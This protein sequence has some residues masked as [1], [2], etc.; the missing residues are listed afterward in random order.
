MK[1]KYKI[2][3]GVFVI[4]I[5]AS[6]I[7]YV[8]NLM[9][10]KNEQENFTLFDEEDDTHET[11]EKYDNKTTKEEKTPIKQETK[12]TYDTRILILK[13]I[14]KIKDINKDIK[15]KLVDI[16]FIDDNIEKIKNYTESERVIFIQSEYDKLKT[17][18]IPIKP[19]V[20]AESVNTKLPSLKLDGFTSLL[21]NDDD[22]KI[23]TMEETI[24]QL[25][26]ELTQL[27]TKNAPPPVDYNNPIIPTPATD[28]IPPLNDQK[29]EGFENIK[30][31]SPLTL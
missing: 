28:A 1:D 27:K 13:D 2:I 5:I 31:Y 6:I 20:H 24:K 10:K 8:L 21:N 3:I 11:I 23:K 14:E 15:T 19:I 18:E 16:L 9:S 17:N 22:S 25:Q 30:M 7:A 12:T 29:I 26:D 4:L